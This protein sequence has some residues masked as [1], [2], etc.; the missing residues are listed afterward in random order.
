MICTQELGIQGHRALLRLLL[1]WGRAKGFRAPSMGGTTAPAGRLRGEARL[2]AL[3]AALGAAQTGSAHVGPVEV[4]TALLYSPRSSR[5]TVSAAGRLP[6][7]A[8]SVSSMRYHTNPPAS[9]VGG[10]PLALE[11]GAVLTHKLRVHDPRW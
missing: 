2:E 7:P 6:S 1:L 10:D 8:S 4:D 9:A 11:I 3:A 5:G